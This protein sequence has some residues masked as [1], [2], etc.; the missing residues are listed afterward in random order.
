MARQQE[1]NI[2]RYSG[3]RSVNSSKE[4]WRGRSV[5]L[6]STVP[7]VAPTSDNPT[8]LVSKPYLTALGCHLYVCAN[9]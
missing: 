8:N 7:V 9:P 6:L 5:R 2:R 1:A 3:V 4:M